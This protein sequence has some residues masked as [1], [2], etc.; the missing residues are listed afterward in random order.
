MLLVPAIDSFDMKYFGTVEQCYPD[1]WFN[2]FTASRLLK[3]LTT[4]FSQINQY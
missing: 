4:Q 3:P 2:L 1:L